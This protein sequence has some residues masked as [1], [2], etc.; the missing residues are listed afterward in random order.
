MPGEGDIAKLFEVGR[1]CRRIEG[2]G[3]HLECV[4][5]PK[6]VGIGSCVAVGM[7]SWSVAAWMKEDADLI[8]GSEKS[9]MPMVWRRQAVLTLPIAA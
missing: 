4:F 6:I 7:G 5:V 9:L 8:V 2:S 3:C 1:A